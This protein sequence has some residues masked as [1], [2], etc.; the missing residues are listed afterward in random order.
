MDAAAT[1]ADSVMLR[2]MDNITPIPI[3]GFSDPVSSISHLVGLSLFGLLGFVLLWRGR[4]SWVRISWLMIF[5]LGTEFLLAMSMTYHLLEPG[6]FAREEVLRRLDHAAIFT[7]I[8]ATMTAAHGILF[9]GVMRWGFITLFWVIVATAVSLKTVFFHDIPEWLGLSLYL[10][11]GWVGLISG[12]ALIR[13]YGFAF[14]APVLWGGIAYSIGAI[15]EALRW[16]VLV[17]NV[18]APHELFHLAVLA[19][20]G[21]HWWFIWGIAKGPPPDERE[22]ARKTAVLERIARDG[23]GGLW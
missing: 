20:L 7:L 15:I 1:T 12:I 8:A 10:G 18:L 6:S 11:F 16:P 14:V 3:P 23:P 5:W 4:G 13:K 9:T 21:W 19:G 22:Q 17:D 2:A